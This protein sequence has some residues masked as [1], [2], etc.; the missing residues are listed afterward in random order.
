MKT[1]SRGHILFGRGDVVVCVVGGLAFVDYLLLDNYLTKTVTTGG[2][3][4]VCGSTGTPVRRHIGSL[5]DEVA[6]RRGM[7]RLGR[8]ALK[9]GGGRGGHNRRMGGFLP[10]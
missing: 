4:P 9:Q 3:R 5:I 10:R 2:G 8:C 6:L 7:R 1:S